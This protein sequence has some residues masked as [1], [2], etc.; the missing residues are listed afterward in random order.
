VSQSQ[1]KEHL[2]LELKA[3]LAIVLYLAA[4]FS[5]IATIKS[6]ILIQLG[7]N[8]FVHGYVTA[9]I[10]SLALGKIVMLAQKIPVLDAT[11]NKP[12]LRSSMFKSAVMT[13][14]V[15]VGSVIEEKIFAPNIEHAP[16]KQVLLISIAHLS[17]LFVVF[18]AL[19]LARGLDKALG[20]GRLLR[21]LTEP[22]PNLP[23]Q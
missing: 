6:L 4:S 22:N 18:Y 16:L 12:L 1:R 13:V 17:T 3:L 9:L 10:E 14:I 5:L 8:D 2:L 23:P 7:I 21:L 11:E 20:P 19:F 15:F